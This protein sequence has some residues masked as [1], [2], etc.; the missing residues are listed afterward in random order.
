MWCV[1]VE[2]V[3]YIYTHITFYWFKKKTHFTYLTT[4]AGSRPERWLPSW[5]L[6]RG[7]GRVSTW[8]VGG[9]GVGVCSSSSTACMTPCLTWHILSLQLSERSFGTH[10]VIWPQLASCTGLPRTET[11]N[12]LTALSNRGRTVSKP[13]GIAYWPC[14][15]QCLLERGSKP[16][17]VHQYLV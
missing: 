10:D 14:L 16:P 1:C 8:G 6:R 13:T 2:R 11:W 9:W 3:I 7:P 4:I 17:I 5:A 15:S 12:P